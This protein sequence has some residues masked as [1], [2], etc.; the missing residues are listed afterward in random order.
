MITGNFRGF[1]VAMHDP[2]VAVVTMNQ[3]ERLNGTTQQM[4]RDFCE[5]IAQ[6][7]MD[8][9]VRVLVVT[10]SGRAFCA[11]DDMTGR[12]P[13][14]AD[15][16]ALAPDI[17]GGHANPIGTYEGLRWLSQP[18][19]VAM[20]SLDKLTVAAING[21]AIQTGLSLALACDFR[22]ASTDARLGSATLRFGLLPDE[23]GQYL[24]VQLLGVARAMDFLMR[25]RIVSAAEALEL[26]LVHEVVEP[27][28]LLP[29][30]LDFA[31]E[32]AEGPQVSMRLLKR[33]IYNAA[34]QTFA[35][36]LDDIAAKTA[37]SDHHPDAREGVAA[38]RERRKPQ[39]NAWLR[40]RSEG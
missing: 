12:R 6:A 40:D 3:P 9:A 15:A 32:L 17:P 22:I 29:R 7:Q 18:L 35:Q 20:R 37:I 26:G 14:R 16:Q 34:E 25:A 13:E 28:A 30:A 10:G 21:V 38:W 2:G 5:I 33:A 11:G 1:E 27:E 23:G 4:K 31:R 8:D 24:L 39:F 36:A 19:N